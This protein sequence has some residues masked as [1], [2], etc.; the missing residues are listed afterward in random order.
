MR[1]PFGIAALFL[2]LAACATQPKGG[3][4][5]GRV[6]AAPDYQQDRFWAALPWRDDAADQTPEGLTDRQQT[7]AADVFFIHPTTYTGKRGHDN[8]NGP[9]RDAELNER[10]LESPIQFQAS[11]FNGV[12]RV[13]APFYRQAHLHAYYT[14]DSLS[15]RRAF[16]IAYSDVRAA[17]RTYL[18][19]H[20]QGRPII[21]ASHSQG[22]TH[23]KRLL[24]EFFDGQDLRRRLVAAYLIGIPVYGD[25]FSSLPPCAS[26]EQTG[27]V[28]AW[29]TFRRGYQPPE[30]DSTVVVTNPLLWTTEDTYA[31][32]SLNLGAVL[33][34]FETVRPGATD[35]QVYGPVLWAARPKFPFRWLMTTKNYHVADM[36]L[37]YRNIRENARVRA[38]AFRKP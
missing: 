7:A 23:A 35:A 28:V 18:G 10:T 38:E 14:D 3:F 19:Q 16:D 12:G 13:F 20:N 15:A 4:E 34:P 11:I 27:C 22:T 29:R 8:W 37:Y 31:P 9:V 17:F 25:D 5:P 6:P 26:A 32:D 24:R 33:R 1:T 21:I 30:S 2:L 36:N